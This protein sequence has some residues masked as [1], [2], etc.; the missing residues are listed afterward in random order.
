[1]TKRGIKLLVF[2]ACFSFF[3]KSFAQVSFYAPIQMMVEPGTTITAPIKIESFQDIIGVSFSLGWDPEVI[4][5]QS[6][7]EFSIDDVT[8]ENFGTNKTAEGKLSF[9]WFDTQGISFADGTTVFSVTFEVIGSPGDTTQLAFTNDPTGQEI[10]DVNF[11]PALNVDFIDGVIKIDQSNGTIDPNKYLN[12]IDCFPNPFDEYTDLRITARQSFEAEVRLFNNTGQ[13]IY[14][15]QAS[16]FKG[17]N[18]LRLD[19]THF[20]QPGSYFLKIT[21]GDLLITKRLIVF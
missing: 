13:V 19:R 4:A 20:G 17:D 14:S 2:L 16:F 1:M 11:P 6:V 12:A 10:L 5:F 3:G 21:S 7:Q 8:I 15:K 18:T 9:L